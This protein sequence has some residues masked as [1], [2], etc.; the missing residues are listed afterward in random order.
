MWSNYAPIKPIVRVRLEIQISMQHIQ[1][2]IN[3]NQCKGYNSKHTKKSNLEHK[4]DPN[5]K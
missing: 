2:K 1:R 5:T 4:K 3:I